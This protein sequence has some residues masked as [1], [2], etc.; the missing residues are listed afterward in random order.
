MVEILLP[1]R[2]VSFSPRIQ[3]Y[4]LEIE[5]Y[6]P[7]LGWL[8]EALMQSACFIITNTMN[9]SNLFAAFVDLPGWF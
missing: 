5:L 1:K 7:V 9:N 2:P 6:F 3:S 4:L 8:G